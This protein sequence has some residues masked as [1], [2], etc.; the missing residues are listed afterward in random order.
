LS[1]Q[2]IFNL[3]RA[4]TRPFA[5]AFSYLG[6]N[7]QQQLRIWRAIPFDPHLLFPSAR[8]GEIVEVFFD[9]TFLVRT[10]DT[11][12]LVQEHEGVAITEEHLGCVLGALGQARKE[13]KHLPY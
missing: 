5:G 7:E 9:G 6:D 8:P 10:G 4:V 1:S 13:W 11:S 2:D 12:L 3:I